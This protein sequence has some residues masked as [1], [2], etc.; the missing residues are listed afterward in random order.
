MKLKEVKFLAE[1]K[2]IAVDCSVELYQDASI[3]L[4]R[5]AGKIGVYVSSTPYKKKMEEKEIEVNGDFEDALK[6]LLGHDYD[7]VEG[8]DGP[9]S[10]EGAENE[11]MGDEEIWSLALLDKNEEALV[12]AE[13][14]G[15]MDEDFEFVRNV[16]KKV[17]EEAKILDKLVE[18]E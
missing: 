18:Q 11:D 13:V 3:R 2:E 14:N 17:T 12:L 6:E 5:K 10:Y 9:G 7:F 15:I 16:L 8:E 4:S 1:V